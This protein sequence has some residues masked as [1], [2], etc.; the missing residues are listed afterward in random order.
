M[1]KSCT[2]MSFVLFPS[3]I[4]RKKIMVNVLTFLECFL[5]KTQSNRYSVITFEP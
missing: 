2:K 1:L 4:G 3:V 5:H